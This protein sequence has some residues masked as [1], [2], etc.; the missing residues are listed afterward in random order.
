M[1]EVVDRVQEILGPILDS[2]GL[3][4]W[5]IEFKGEGP[6]WLLRIYIDSESGVTIEDCEAVSRDIGTALDVED[7]ITHSYTLEVSSPG[8]D[9]SLS[10]PEHF[11]RFIGSR[12]KVK[13]FQPVE[14]Q[15]AF[16]AEIAGL[17]DK[18]LRLRLDSGAEIDTPLTNIAKASL[19]LEI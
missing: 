10:R 12:I 2:L 18:M 17:N 15:K 19:E 16:H 4:L 1:A 8:L 13:T 14:G 11:R 9:R 5:D 6:R 3:F 7:I